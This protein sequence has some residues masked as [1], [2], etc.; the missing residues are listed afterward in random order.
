VSAAEGERPP[1]AARSRFAKLGFL[2]IGL[3]VAAYLGMRGPHEQHLRLVLGDAAPDV[4]G[5]E[6]Q[7]VDQDGEVARAA[8]LS[9]PAGGAPRVVSHEPELP[10]GTY[11]LRVNVATRE[12]RV[13]VERSVTLGGGSTQVDLSQAL[14]AP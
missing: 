8:R 2:L 13:P 1:R 3:A 12:R 7:Y 6:I 11:A 10:D 9:Y 4:T 5:L 14:K